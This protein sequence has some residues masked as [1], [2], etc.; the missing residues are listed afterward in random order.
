MTLNDAFESQTYKVVG[1]GGFGNERRRLLDM[2][3]APGTNVEVIAHAPFKGTVLVALR[4]FKV[5]LREDAAMLIELEGS[6]I[7]RSR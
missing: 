7:C 3:F 2:G 4:D 6:D 1:V 5:A